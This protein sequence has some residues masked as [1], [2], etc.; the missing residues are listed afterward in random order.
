MTDDFNAE[1][2]RLITPLQILGPMTEQL[3]KQILKANN[4]DFH[5]VAYRVKGANSTLRKINK[6]DGRRAIG[7]LT[8]M[9]GLR[10]I[11]YLRDDVDKIAKI[12]E[13]EFSVDQ[14][15]SIDKRAVLDPD[16]F[17]YL[18]MHYIVKLSSGRATLTEYEAFAETKFEIQIRSIL[19]H[20]WAEIEHDLGYKSEAAV[21]RSTRRSFSRLAGL[22]ELADDEFTRIRDELAAQQSTVEA[23]IREGVHN[24]EIDQNSLYSYLIT[25]QDYQLLERRIG[26]YF[27]L[28]LQA[29]EASAIG[30]HAADLQSVGFNSIDEIDQFLK[31]ELTLLSTFAKLWVEE[32][33]PDA[34]PQDP[35]T[36]VSSGIGFYYIC[37]F[38]LAKGMVEGESLEG[39]LKDILGPYLD[40]LTSAYNEA[41][42]RTAES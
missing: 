15:N 34:V 13:R 7:S 39:R 11:T 27:D 1:Y 20:A 37:I 35:T 16:R 3:V 32:D 31:S 28:P 5:S 38:R 26:E 2:V 40:E 25:S 18:S 8:D 9:L 22:L 6:S 23:E 17:G 24:I 19:Q 4:I 41:L 29:S 36:Q 30:H 10:I 33:Y 12:V 21:P 14:E 42:R